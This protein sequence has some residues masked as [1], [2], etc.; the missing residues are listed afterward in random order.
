V[1]RIAPVVGPSVSLAWDADQE[2]LS[3]L[4]AGLRAHRSLRGLPNRVLFGGLPIRR[5]VT[6]GRSLRRSAQ[7]AFSV[8]VRFAR[9]ILP[10]GFG[11]IPVS[12]VFDSVF[13]ATGALDLGGSDP[14]RLHLGLRPQRLSP[15]AV[16]HSRRRG[17][18][19]WYSARTRDVALRHSADPGLALLGRRPVYGAAAVALAHSLVH[20]VGCRE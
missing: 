18:H 14:G 10:G 16:L 7:H 12:H 15:T 6:G 20:S 9:R 4:S 1:A 8:A 3:R 11:G 2:F 17:R 5:V 13:A 19:R